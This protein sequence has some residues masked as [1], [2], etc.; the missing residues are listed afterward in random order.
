MV[1]YPGKVSHADC[2]RIGTMGQIFP[3]QVETLVSEIEK[4]L[5]QIG[6]TMPRPE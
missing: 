6:V 1:I 4:V 2:F 5:D 3:E